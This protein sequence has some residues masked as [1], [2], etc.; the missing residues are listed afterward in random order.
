MFSC[1]GLLWLTQYPRP[2]MLFTSNKVRLPNPYSHF[3]H[4]FWETSGPAIRVSLLLLGDA[5]SLLSYAQEQVYSYF[6][7]VKLLK[8]MSMLCLDMSVCSQS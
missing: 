6:S 3:V 7:S 8:S 2:H 4:L 5:Q 1:P